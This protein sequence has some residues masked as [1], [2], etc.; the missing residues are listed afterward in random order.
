MVFGIRAAVR[1]RVTADLCPWRSWF[2][3]WLA[4]L[5]SKGFGS[6]RVCCRAQ[7]RCAGRVALMKAVFA[8]VYI[9]SI[10]GKFCRGR[11]WARR[12]EREGSGRDA[13][14]LFTLG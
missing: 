8:A 14:A 13:R 6:E 5:L 4:A 2:T 11:W 12:G 1:P 10:V 7:A 3:G 9:L